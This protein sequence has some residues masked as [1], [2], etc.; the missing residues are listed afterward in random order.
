MRQAPRQMPSVNSR[1]APG[2]TEGTWRGNCL[3]AQVCP[4]AARH[5]S[6]SVTV[7]CLLRVCSVLVFC[8][9]FCFCALCLCIVPAATATASA[10]GATTTAKQQQQQ[11]QPRQ[12]QRQQQPTAMGA[13]RHKKAPAVT[14]EGPGGHIQWRRRSQTAPAVT[15]G[16]AGSHR[17]RCWQSRDRQRRRP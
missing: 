1:A 15:D 2:V 8:A 16:A 11:Q 13:S 9:V 4:Q 10:M 14:D 3:N 5:I 17:R 6:S 12:R 7:L